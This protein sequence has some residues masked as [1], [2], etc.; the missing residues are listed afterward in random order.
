MLL[1]T[2]YVLRDGSDLDKSYCVC[3]CVR[4]CVCVCVCVCVGSCTIDV[5]VCVLI[6][7]A[8][9]T[10]LFAWREGDSG[11]HVLRE[12]TS[13]GLC[14]LVCPSRASERGRGNRRAISYGIFEGRGE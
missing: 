13:P 8:P 5:G 11:G 14:G 1:N 2:R 9:S 4:V 3:V 12:T 6:T 10:K 7:A